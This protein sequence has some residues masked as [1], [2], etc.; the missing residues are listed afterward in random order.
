MKSKIFKVRLLLPN[1]IQ[2]QYG[3]LKVVHSDLCITEVICKQIPPRFPNCNTEFK[4]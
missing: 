3:T 2:M 4:I 1:L